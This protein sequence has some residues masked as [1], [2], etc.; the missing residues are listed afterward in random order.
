MPS[1]TAIVPMSW[2]AITTP[3]M[4]Y[5]SVPNGLWS[6]CGSPL[7]SQMMKPLIATSRPIVTM[8]IRSTLPRSTGRITT[9][10]MQ[11]PPTNEMRR[12][13]TNAGA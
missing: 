9:R 6:C 10:W 2:A 3:P 13:A 8:T 11:T 12:V 1:A 5:V 4:E 7:H